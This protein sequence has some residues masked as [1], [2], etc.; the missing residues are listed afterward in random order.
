MSAAWEE[1]LGTARRLDAVRR[2]AVTV[3]G[4]QSRAARATV[5]ELTRVRA[6]L[7]AQHNRLREL[8]VPEE[9]LYPSPAELTAAVAGGPVAA[10]AT[11]GGD[12]AGD[13]AAGDDPPA[14]P[15][16]ATPEGPGAVWTALRR[17]RAL[18]ES[19]DAALAPPRRW[20]ALVSR[21]RG[22]FRRPPG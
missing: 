16:A 14:A 19:A 1:Y 12:V 18:A 17:S 8:G 2:G 6:R 15:E 4:E 3:E 9:E 21:I 13:G 7:A 22:L 20:Q 10:E 11:A 5:E